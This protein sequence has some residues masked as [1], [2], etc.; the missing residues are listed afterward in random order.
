MRPLTTGIGPCHLM[1][2][3][4]ARVSI[5][6][7]FRCSNNRFQKL[8]ELPFR[9]GGD[10]QQKRGSSARN[11]AVSDSQKGAPASVGRATREPKLPA[12]VAEATPPGSGEV[13][14]G[15]HADRG[16]TLAALYDTGVLERL[17][18]DVRVRLMADLT[19]SLAWL[20]ANPRLMTAHRHL[21]IA[22]TTV[23]I[24]LDGVARVD[25]R[26][27]K[28]RTSD[29]SELEA[30]YA[31]P[32]VAS[33]SPNADHRADL[34]SLGVITW[35]AL[36][37]HRI[38]A[39]TD[40]W[41]SS[42]RTRRTHAEPEPFDAVPVALGPAS[43]RETAQRRAPGAAPRKA[44]HSRV[45]T[46]PTLT[47]PPGGEW[48]TGIAE[49]ALLAMSQEAAQRPA[50]CRELLARFD[51][52]DSALFATHQEIAEVI[53][54]IS[55]VATLCVPEPALPN[56]DAGCHES[57]SSANGAHRDVC[58]TATL[59]CA[60]GDVS[61]ARRVGAPAA[62]TQSEP[63]ALSVLDPG[64]TAPNVARLSVAR[65]GYSARAWFVAGLLW[66]AVLGSLAGYVASV[67]A[68]R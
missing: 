66:L 3:S 24:G 45:K 39:A 57:D 10:M 47:L 14:L 6:A 61:A 22:P 60:R 55:A 27:A 30:Q 43:A 21:L 53:Q 12:V 48:A 16:L 28:K 18:F 67:L 2:H 17:R 32:E 31:A 8:L 41:T 9:I 37:G 64:A 25:V 33:G 26:A 40:A 5:Y 42:D 49:I 44:S 36:A 38:A 46:P 4:R 63:P 11:R 58:F 51:A 62:P 34:F 15:G 35:E 50:D 7:L 23:V 13:T 20:H 65:P 52:I 29:Q 54:G 1:P 56:P 59:D 68:A 19:Q